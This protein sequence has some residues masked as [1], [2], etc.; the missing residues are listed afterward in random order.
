MLRSL[1]FLSSTC[2]RRDKGWG[3]SLTGKWTFLSQCVSFP[4][5]HNKLSKASKHPFLFPHLQFSLFEN[6]S[7]L[8]RTGSSFSDLILR[9]QWSE[10]TDMHLDTW[11]LKKSGVCGGWVGG[12]EVKLV[13]SSSEILD[14]TIIEGKP[15][16]PLARFASEQLPRLSLKIEYN[17]LLRMLW[18]GWKLKTGTSRSRS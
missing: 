9:N 6:F 13:K 2:S 1:R 5:P 14:Q 12:S 10:V 15:E 17:H 16:L 3:C 8:G 4:G 11:K 7:F 18:K